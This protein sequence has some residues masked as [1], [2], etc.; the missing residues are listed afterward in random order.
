MGDETADGYDEDI[1]TASKNSKVF[2]KLVNISQ[3]SV[4]DNLTSIDGV[5]PV[6]AM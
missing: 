6:A 1:K 5:I 3:L 4:F 2:N